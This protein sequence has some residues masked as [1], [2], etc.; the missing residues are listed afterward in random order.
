M[1]SCT[2]DAESA[3]VTGGSVGSGRRRNAGLGDCS[4]CPIDSPALPH[5]SRVLATPDIRERVGRWRV[6][7]KGVR[8]GLR[9]ETVFEARF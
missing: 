4:C 7:G 8:V 1:V 9:G 6:K 2:G 3:S 5:S